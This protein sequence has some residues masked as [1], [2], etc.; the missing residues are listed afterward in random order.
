MAQ[1]TLYY[2]QWSLFSTVA[3]YTIAL[4]G[5]PSSPAL[6]MNIEEKVIDLYKAE[7]I[8]EWYLVNI[9]PKGQVPAL[10]SPKLPSPITETLDITYLLSESYPRLLP[11]VHRETIK[12]LLSELN[13]ISAFALSFEPPKNQAEGSPNPKIDQ[14]LAQPDISDT[15][16]KALEFKREFHAKTLLRGLDEEPVQRAKS[17]AKEYFKKVLEQYTLYNKGGAWIFGDEIGPTALDAHVI[18]WTVRIVEAGNAGLIPD[19]IQRYAERATQAAEWQSIKMG[20]P[21]KFNTWLKMLEKRHAE[22]GIDEPF[23]TW[24]SRQIT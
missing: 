4:R 6:A 22:E 3:R 14:Y 5:E 2:F 19:E 12:S 21:T 18:T 8:S 13:S 1:Y 23:N 10:A 24:A 15:W 9:N 16:R 7:N 17:Q 20:R 11:S